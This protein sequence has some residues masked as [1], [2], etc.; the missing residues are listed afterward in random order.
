MKNNEGLYLSLDEARE[1]LH[2]RWANAE[3]KNQ[4]EA[5]LGDM[6]MPQ[7]KDE[8]RGVS[9]RQV[10]SPDNGFVFF[11]Q[12]AKYVGVS[13]LVLE[14]HD[15]LFVHFNEEKKGLGRLRITLE[16]GER[17]MVD[18]MDFHAAE[19]KSLKE[20]KIKT[21]ESLVGFHHNL[22]RVSGYDIELCEN[23]KWFNDIGKAKKYYYYLLLHFIAHGFISENLFEG[24][25]KTAKFRDDIM[26]PAI[27]EIRGKFELYIAP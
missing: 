25:D 27:K 1:E 24:D 19:K 14:F 6:F 4:I 13:P 22:F 11:Y 26:L 2:K 17:A 5:E 18:I 10:C 7:F 3:L 12:C 8:P 9:F 21:G 16:D 20:V 15:D 23:S